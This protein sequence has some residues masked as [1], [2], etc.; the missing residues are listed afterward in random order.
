M[1]IDYQRETQPD[2]NKRRD[3]GDADTVSSHHSENIIEDKRLAQEKEAGDGLRKSRSKDSDNG[4]IKIR[5]EDE[6]PINYNKRETEEEGP[7]IV[8][9][10]FESNKN[11]SK[12][13]FH[14][15]RIY[16]SS[17]TVEIALF[18]DAVL[19]E[20]LYSFYSEDQLIDLILSLMNNVSIF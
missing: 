9:D 19:L 20:N 7:A 2:K 10:N 11:K 5:D 6:T 14:S 17:L 16:S 12:K 18:L 1:Y 3:E 8:P 15:G 4:D 13:A